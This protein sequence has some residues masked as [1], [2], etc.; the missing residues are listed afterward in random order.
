MNEISVRD[1][2]VGIREDLDWVI[3]QI[4]AAGIRPS[5]IARRADVSG[6]YLSQLRRVETYPGKVPSPASLSRIVRAIRFASDEHSSKLA[7]ASAESIRMIDERLRHLEA[8][9][10]SVLPPPGPPLPVSAA[11]YVT[12]DIDHKLRRYLRIPTKGLQIYMVTG[13]PASG[14]T[15]LQY[16]LV[17]IAGP[18]FDTVVSID[19]STAI[20]DGDSDKAD[21][22]VQFAI[23][24]ACMVATGEVEHPALSDD[25]VF[26]LRAARDILAVRGSALLLLDGA[27]TEAGSAAAGQI[28]RRWRDEASGDSLEAVVRV[29]LFSSYGRRTMSVARS[30]LLEGNLPDLTRLRTEWFSFDE[31]QRLA[32]SYTTAGSGSMTTPGVA[33]Q[34]AYDWFRGQPMLTHQMIEDLLLTGLAPQEA[35]RELERPGTTY[36][37]HLKHLARLLDDE[38]ERPQLLG[39][40]LSAIQDDEP[41]PRESL[42]ETLGVTERDRFEDSDGVVTTCSCRFYR[43]GLPRL[44]QQRLQQRQQRRLRKEGLES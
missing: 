5:E 35:I 38:E 4:S 37:A 39:A 17:D 19:L 44:L 32:D 22:E 36:D 10:A 31:V 18:S 8:R 26:A 14:K 12:R 15:S 16:R 27:N 9:V 23:A 21:E 28:N 13:P 40:A 2:M 1:E 7:L 42:L 41:G 30:S 3:K 20:T 24:R 34:I 33:A 43:Q 6:S 29:V 25:P 11:T